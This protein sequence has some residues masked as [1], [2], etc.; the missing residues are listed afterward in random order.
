MNEEVRADPAAAIY[1]R[2]AEQWPTVDFDEFHQQTLPALLD[3]GHGGVVAPALAD[4]TPI[5]FKLKGGQAY[6][7]LVDGQTISVVEGD[8][9]ADTVI[10]TTA[11][12]FS[13]FA[14]QLHSAHGLYFA[15]KIQVPVGFANTL[16]EWEPAIRAMYHGRPVYDPDRLDL[17]DRSGKPLDLNR[18]FTPDDD[19]DQM[20]HF[21][22]EAGF[23]HVRGLF[24]R[25]EIAR[26]NE[27]TDEFCN[28]A[29]P[30]DRNSW[31]CRDDKGQQQLCRLIYLS[32]R[33]EVMS[34][35]ARDKRLER[36]ATRF[37]KGNQITTHDRLDGAAVIMK[38][39]G[40]VEGLADLPW[41]V[42][43]GLG[44][45]SVMCTTLQ[46]SLLLGPANPDTGNLRVMA[47]SHQGSCNV[48]GAWDSDVHGPT[49]VDLNG[50]AGDCVLHL[51]DTLHTA[52]PPKGN[53]PY[54]RSFITSYYRP[55]VLD[56]VGPG[57]GFNDLIA[58]RDDG[59]VGAF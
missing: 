13:D 10:E 26:M 36:L 46:M 6:T 58:A 28:K 29:E 37:G 59:M 11:A 55:E 1:D 14:N 52:P 40:V 42:D 51:S 33:S 48:G 45:H 20:R 17:R 56:M 8:S 18:A 7:Y 53:G 41:H 47:G 30:G 54:R 31:W 23:L 12:A 4:K 25:D 19:D 34:E 57:Q 44:G 38:V 9:N 35:A 32:T 5:A 27:A 43:C 24:G 2:L 3:G 16:F 39:P 15:G 21:L 50:E 22:G 49:L